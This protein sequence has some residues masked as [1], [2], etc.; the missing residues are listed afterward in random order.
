MIMKE[1]GVNKSSVLITIWLILK[2]S[3]YTVLFSVKKKLFQRF[4][5][6]QHRRLKFLSYTQTKNKQLK[7]DGAIQNPFQLEKKESTIIYFH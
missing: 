7:L 5:H 1:F 2:L 3:E 6:L 4:A